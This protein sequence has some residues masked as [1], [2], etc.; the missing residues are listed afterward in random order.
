MGSLDIGKTNLIERVKFYNNYPRYKTSQA[1]IRRTIAYDF[2]TISVKI[3]NKI[4]KILLWDSVGYED[5]KNL[6]SGRY[7]GNC[8]AYLIA[9]DAFNRNSF[10]NGIKFYEGQY[11]Y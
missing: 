7:K 9:Y 11:I 6:F 4:T 10:T 1:N 2:E 3:N 8:D 5:G